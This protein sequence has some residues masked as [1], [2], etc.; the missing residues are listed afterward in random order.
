M[1]C[2]LKNACSGASSADEFANQ[3]DEEEKRQGCDI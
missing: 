2:E 3:K 1:I